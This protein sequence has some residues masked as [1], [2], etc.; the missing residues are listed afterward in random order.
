MTDQAKPVR[1]TLHL[2]SSAKIP[3]ADQADERTSVAQAA[4]RSEA[5]EGD[6]LHPDAPPVSDDSPVRVDGRE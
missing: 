2:A 5:A 6:G 1:K 3:P 4:F